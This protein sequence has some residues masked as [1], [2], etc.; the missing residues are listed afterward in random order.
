MNENLLFT[1]NKTSRKVGANE[2]RNLQA[3]FFFSVFLPLKVITEICSFVGVITTYPSPWSHW[4]QVA[5]SG[6]TRS[7]TKQTEQINLSIC[8]F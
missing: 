6:T 7:G 2:P 1:F 5:L 4:L 8:C 3:T